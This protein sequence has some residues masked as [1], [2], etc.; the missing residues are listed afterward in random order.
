MDIYDRMASWAAEAIVENELVN[1]AADWAEKHLDAETMKSVVS[2]AME[3]VPAVGDYFGIEALKQVKE[4]LENPIV[5]DLV[6]AAIDSAI[7][8]A[9]EIGKELRLQKDDRVLAVLEADIRETDIRESEA[10]ETAIWEAEDL[11]AGA[12]EDGIRG[13]A[14]KAADTIEELTV[15]LA[16]AMEQEPRE[17]EQAIEELNRQFVDE[18]QELID[19]LGKMEKA[20]F[21]KHPDLDASQRDAAE[22]RFEDIR[23]EELDSLGGRQDARLEEV[24]RTQQEQRADFAELKQELDDTR[25]ERS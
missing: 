2:V 1:D 17:S 25:D 19:K 12:L 23:K 13:D 3:V 11:E 14:E 18:Q 15:E 21:D 22:D 5:A 4:F 20:Y 16:E 7:D 10:L 9:A 24:T 6:E 8:L